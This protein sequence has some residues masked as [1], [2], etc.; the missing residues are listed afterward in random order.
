[1][2]L[3]T[4]LGHK[5][6]FFKSGEAQFVT[7]GIIASGYESASGAGTADSVRGAISPSERGG[8]VVLQGLCKSQIQG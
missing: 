7:V 5:R 1:M 2:G 8:Q 3:Y 4:A 6:H